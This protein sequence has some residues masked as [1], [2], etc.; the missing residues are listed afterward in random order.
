MKAFAI[1]FLALFA[2]TCVNGQV[3]GELE[4][5]SSR[6]NSSCAD[7]L[8]DIF[9]PGCD[10]VTGCHIPNH[11]VGITITTSNSRTGETTFT[12]G[13]LQIDTFT[14][15]L[16]LT[17]IA[18]PGFWGTLSSEALS[19]CAGL[20]QP[21]DVLQSAFDINLIEIGQQGQVFVRSV[22][23]F[24]FNF[25]LTCPHCGSFP[26]IAFVGELTIIFQ[27]SIFPGAACPDVPI[28]QPCNGTPCNC[29]S[30]TPQPPASPSP[31]PPANKRWF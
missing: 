9:G 16:V 4:D 20:G 8:F 6:P 23:G 2:L 22:E 29:P 1:L 19:C 5:I 30:P 17:Q 11:G 26:A 27:F 24:S 3:F 28:N 31:S 7:A 12:R 25:T 15:N 18:R 14:P 10:N 21:F 13:C